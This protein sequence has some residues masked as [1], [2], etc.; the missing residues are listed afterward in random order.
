MFDKKIKGNFINTIKGK[1]WIRLLRLEQH[2]SVECSSHWIFTRPKQNL[3]K[4]RM[5][6]PKLYL[7]KPVSWTSH[8]VLKPTQTRQ[9]LIFLTIQV[10]SYEIESVNTP[11]FASLNIIMKA[12]LFALLLRWHAAVMLSFWCWWWHLARASFP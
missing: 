6:K 5:I 3:N 10:F 12:T 8:W 9:W 7:N 1:R 4:I 2:E 11:H